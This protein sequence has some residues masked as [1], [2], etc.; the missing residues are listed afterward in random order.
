MVNTGSCPSTLPASTQNGMLVDAT[1]SRIG[2]FATGALYVY[3]MTAYTDLTPGCSGTIYRTPR[4]GGVSELVTEAANVTAIAAAGDQLYWVENGT[5]VHTQGGVVLAE[6]TGIQLFQS[7]ASV[8]VVDSQQVSLAGPTELTRVS[9]RPAD[10]GQWLAWDGS[11]VYTTTAN[12]DALVILTTEGPTALAHDVDTYG[13][14]VAVD[15]HYVY[16]ATGWPPSMGVSRIEKHGAGAAQVLV[17]AQ[18]ELIRELVI[19]PPF[20]F[21][22]VDNG[23]QSIFLDTSFDS[24]FASHDTPPLGLQNDGEHVVYMLDAYARYGELTGPGGFI[25]YR[26]WLPK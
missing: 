7:G 24:V 17:P 4:D 13:R 1:I 9:G 20:L 8:L 12:D 23:I 5:T 26:E 25:A 15:E 11:A 6:E 19:T 14:T 10:M 18:S 22:A 16:Y 3:W 21:Y 2:G